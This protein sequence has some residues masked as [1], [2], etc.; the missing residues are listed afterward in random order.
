MNEKMSVSYITTD[1]GEN[2][3]SMN[4][5]MLSPKYAAKVQN[6]MKETESETKNLKNQH[7]NPKPQAVQNIKLKNEQVPVPPL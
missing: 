2:L 6:E 5:D 4:N 7:N 3:S 1:H